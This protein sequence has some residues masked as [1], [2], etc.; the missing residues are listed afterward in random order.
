MNRLQIRPHSRKWS[1][2]LHAVAEEIY[3]LEINTGSALGVYVVPHDRIQHTKHFF[4][5]R[6]ND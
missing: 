6:S 1:Q 5:H 4:A 3:P 2:N